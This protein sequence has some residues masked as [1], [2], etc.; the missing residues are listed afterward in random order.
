MG[1]SG[2]CFC[3]I[4][5]TDVVQRERIREGALLRSLDSPGDVLASIEME[6]MQC[7]L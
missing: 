4:S 2:Y 3:H 5:G 6:I 1:K 7:S